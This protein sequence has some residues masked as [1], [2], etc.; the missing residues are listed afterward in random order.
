LFLN[1]LGGRL[2]GDGIA[3]V[4]IKAATRCELHDPQSTK[5]EDRLGPHCG[6]VWFSAW[7]ERNG[8]RR[9]DIQEL[10]GD[11]IR[12]AVDGY[13][14]VEDYELRESYLAHIPQLGL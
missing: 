2:A 6:R 3:K 12:A 11:A 5:L 9:E 4:V 14:D 10:R 7:L 8:M 13:I 1:Y